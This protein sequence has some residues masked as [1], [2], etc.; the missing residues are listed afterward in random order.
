LSASSKQQTA[1]NSSRQQQ[2]AGNSSKQQQAAPSSSKPQQTAVNCSKW[3][4]TAANSSKKQQT[5]LSSVSGGPFLSRGIQEFLSNEMCLMFLVWEERSAHIRVD[6][7]V[8][9]HWIEILSSYLCA[10]FLMEV[11]A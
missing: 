7:M 4:Q 10:Q 3:Q 5:K 11:F 1:A 6:L 2:T 9:L 8:C